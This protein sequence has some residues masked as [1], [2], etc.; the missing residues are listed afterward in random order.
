MSLT[1]TAPH[2]ID[3]AAE[4]L[5]PEALAFIEKLHQNFAGT[6]TER[7]A[8]RGERRALVAR[9]G[10]LDFLPETADVRAGDW[11][12][13]PAPA[14]LTDRRVEMT[15]PASPA[16]M[17]VNALNSGAKVW[18]ADLEDACT[19]TW[20]NVIDSQLSLFDAARGRMPRSAW[21]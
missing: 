21:S 9:T 16:K 8:A 2:P 18:L 20:H 4:I 15:G 14:Q 13:A 12:V 11:T 6:R 1:L 19:P 10:K 7:L 17:A 5:T 3:R